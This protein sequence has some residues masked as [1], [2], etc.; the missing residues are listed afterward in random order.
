MGLGGR[1]GSEMVPS[2]S[3][4]SYW[5]ARLAA[6][7]L[8]PRCSRSAAPVTAGPCTFLPPW[9]ST[10]PASDCPASFDG[11]PSDPRYNVALVTLLQRPSRRCGDGFWQRLLERVEKV[12]YADTQCNLS[13]VQ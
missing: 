1:R 9:L 10:P 12:A 5:R 11:L 6:F 3:A 2:R 8:R 13:R 4:R 7:W